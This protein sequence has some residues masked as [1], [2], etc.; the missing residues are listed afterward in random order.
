MYHKAAR[1]AQYFTKE[2]KYRKIKVDEKNES[3]LYIPARE[4]SLD[5]LMDD[6]GEQFSD[7]S[8]H[9]EDEACFALMCDALYQALSQ[10]DAQERQLIHCR[11]ASLF[12]PCTSNRKRKDNGP[13]K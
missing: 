1:K 11:N 2:L 9:V 4:D 12:M 3:V 8:V 5:R 13:L 10:L 7:T 6:N